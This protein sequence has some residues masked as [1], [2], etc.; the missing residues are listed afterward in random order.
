MIIRIFAVLDTKIGSFAQP[1]FMS[2]VPA[3]KRAF[4]EACNDPST[5]LHKHPGDF[6]LYL[7]GEFNDENGQLTPLQPDNLG[8]AAS[9][10]RVN[11][12]DA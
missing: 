4:M 7:L 6:S 9:Y 8:T 12:E 3:A 10:V 11:S 5:M 1:F 2:T